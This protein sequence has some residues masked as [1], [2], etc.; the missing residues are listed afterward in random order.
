MLGKSFLS[1]FIE[2]YIHSMEAF[3]FVMKHATDGRVSKDQF[4]EAYGF[5][6]PK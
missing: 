3:E 2:F 4:L 5:T 6:K 1:S